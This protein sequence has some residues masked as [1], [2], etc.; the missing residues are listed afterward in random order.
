MRNACPTRHCMLQEPRKAAR[1]VRCV[2]G[3]MERSARWWWRWAVRRKGEGHTRPPVVEGCRHQVAK[4]RG[5]CAC[6]LARCR[7]RI[8]EASSLLLVQGV[9]QTHCCFV[10]ERGTARE[11]RMLPFS[12]S[13]PRRW[14]RQ[15]R[16]HQFSVSP[17]CRIA[18]K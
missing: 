13:A 15:R 4:G 3:R 17:S 11:P 14:Q 7:M 9:D 10:W 1:M 18:F 6:G 5:A 16:R 8:E 2:V 12:E